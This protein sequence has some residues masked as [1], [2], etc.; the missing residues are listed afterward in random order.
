VR[1]VLPSLALATALGSLLL[2]AGCASHRAPAPVAAA[3]K[4]PSYTQPEVPADLSVTPTVRREYDVA[5][6]RLQAGDLQ[7]ATAALADVV[8]QNPGFYPAEAAL[9]DLALVQRQARSAVDHFT[10][11]LS[12]NGRYLPALEGRVQAA[13][14][15]GDDFATA[16]ALEQLLAVDPTREEAAARLG[17]VRLRI[18]QGQLAAAANARTAGRLPEAQTIV[19]RA[20]QISPSSPVLLRELAD[21]ERTRDALPSAEQHARRAVELDGADPESLAVLGAVLEREGKIVE[22]ADAFA[23]A[24]SLDP[25]PAWREKRDA[26][27]ARARFEALPAEYRAIPTATTIT[28]A[29]VAAAIGIDLDALLSRATRSSA[30]VLTDVRASWAAGWILRVTQAGIM[31]A[32]PNHTFQANAIVRRSD[33]AQVASQLLTLAATLHPDEAAKWRASRP[34]LEDVPAG[35]VAYRAI[36]LCVGAGAMQLDETGRFWPGRPASGADLT[37]VVARLKPLAR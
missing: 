7:A 23:R 13:L 16:F 36:V 35:H 14:A 1:G 6:Q 29:Q 20:L 31:D 11:A 33:L 30:V 25:R 12:S 19:E 34:R 8:A 15:L 37:A 32:Y 28:R 27:R 4:Y 26:L 17:R 9:G 24:L 2:F 10:A 5:W 3:P 22:A 21:I 18:V